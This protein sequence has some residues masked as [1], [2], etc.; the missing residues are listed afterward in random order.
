LLVWGDV[1]HVPAVQLP[2]PDI[3]IDYDIDGPSA[4]KAREQLFDELAA[5][6]TLIAGAH[7]QFPALGRLRKD[8]P[9]YAWVPVLYSDRP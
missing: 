2:R 4:I 1:V 3:G 7:M 8:G 6:G 9:G 5:K